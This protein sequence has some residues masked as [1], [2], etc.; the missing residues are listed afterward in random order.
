MG[1]EIDNEHGGCAGY[2]LVKFQ[3]GLTGKK[4]QKIVK[5][6]KITPSKAVINKKKIIH[7]IAPWSERD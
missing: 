3:S 2:L 4:K 1:C 7:S 5:F 6:K